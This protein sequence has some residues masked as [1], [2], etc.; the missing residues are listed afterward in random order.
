MSRALRER[1]AFFTYVASHIVLGQLMNASP[2]LNTA[3]GSS[4]AQTDG[5]S[6]SARLV[7]DYDQLQEY[8]VAHPVRDGDAWLRGLAATAP[9]L[10]TRVA[11]VRLAY[12]TDE[13]GCGFEWDSLRRLA[14]EEMRDGNLAVMR[15][16]AASLVPR[17]E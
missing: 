8:L 13:E 7:S 2:R 16:W 14:E 15:D 11:A 17:S 4:A 12:G 10:A 9:R 5:A 3:D 1:R 6:E